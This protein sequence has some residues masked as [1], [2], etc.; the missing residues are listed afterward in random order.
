[1]R[2]L[3]KQ[4]HET[5]VVCRDRFAQGGSSPQRSHSTLSNTLT[6]DQGVKVYSL[7]HEVPFEKSLDYV[8]RRWSPDCLLV[9]EDPTFLSLAVGIDQT[10]MRIIVLTLSQA[11]LPF[12][13]EAFHPNPLCT[14][15]LQ[16]PVEILVLTNYVKDYIKKWGGLDAVCLPPLLGE[17]RNASQLG[18][19]DNPFVMMVNPSKIKGLSIFFGLAQR[20]P[21]HQFA[22]VRGWATTQ[23]DVTQ[24]RQ[25]GNVR[26]LQPEENVDE[27]YSKAKVL[28]VPS[29]W[30]E[31][32]GKVT[33]EAMGRGI[34]VLASNVGG[35]PEAK[36]HVDYLLPVQPISEYVQSLD[37]HLLPDPIV[38]EQDLEPWHQALNRLLHDREHYDALSQE[39][40]RVTLEWLENLDENQWVQYIEGSLKVSSGDVVSFSEKT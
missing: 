5:V 8:I 34:P 20:F 18:S 6:V 26:I 15:L 29:L 10:I 36:L 11:T 21:R 30:G 35:L 25:L 28:L 2:L 1:M 40:R 12:G 27:I 39:S 37:E 38:P 14:K 23:G 17:Q 7:P 22:A 16:P 32:L 3:A 31:A 19:F 33:I 4:G 9:G 24:L 13:P